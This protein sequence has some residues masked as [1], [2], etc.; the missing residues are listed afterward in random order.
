MP[1]TYECGGS[2]TEDV[3]LFTGGTE[4]ARGTTGDEDQCEGGL[5]LRSTR[6]PAG[7]MHSAEIE[8]SIDVSNGPVTLYAFVEREDS[9]GRDGGGWDLASEGFVESATTFES[10]NRYI[11]PFRVFHREFSDATPSAPTSTITREYCNLCPEGQEMLNR[12]DATDEFYYRGANGQLS[13]TTCAEVANSSGRQC[14]FALEYFFTDFAPD[15]AGAYAGCTYP[16]GCSAQYWR[17][18]N[19]ALGNIREDCG[20]I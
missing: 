18:Q 7:T 6:E 20:C 19:L 4:R 17:N 14:D 12:D 11:G 5:L 2:F 13:Q 15:G 9:Q 10:T 16:W 8:I 3:L 1:Y